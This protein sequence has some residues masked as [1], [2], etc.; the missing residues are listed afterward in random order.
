MQRVN[1]GQQ[2]AMMAAPTWQARSTSDYFI[3]SHPWPWCYRKVNPSLDC[4]SFRMC[5]HCSISIL[6][7][8]VKFLMFIMKKFCVYLFIPFFQSYILFESWIKVLASTDCMVV[9]FLY[10]STGDSELNILS[11][12][13][14]CCSMNNTIPNQKP[15]PEDSIKQNRLK[16]NGTIMVTLK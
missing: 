14:C 1:Y 12:C 7:Q 2:A 11:R 13:K 4:D 5:V 9:Y 15:Y 10:L 8:E 6:I 16:W 3:W